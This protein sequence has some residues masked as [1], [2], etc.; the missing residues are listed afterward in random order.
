MIN[1]REFMAGTGLAGL[2]LAR[3]ARALAAAPSAPV[4]VA[5]CRSYGTEFL[6]ATEKMFDQ[7]GGLGRLVKG[8]TVTIKINLTG[9]ETTRLDYLPQGRTFWSHPRTVGAVIHLMDKAGARRIRVVEGAWV[10]PASLEEFMLKA[11][12]NPDLLLKAAPAVELINTNL[13]YKGS[14]PYTRFPVPRQG[15]LFP[16]YDL[17]TAYAESDVLVSMNKIKE[18]GTAGVT[19]SIKN[20]F[21]ISP[22]TIYGNKVPLDEPAPVPYGGRQEIGHNG[23]RQPPTSSPSEIDPKS[24]RQAGY[25][26][27]RFIADLVAA[28]PVHLAILD[29]IETITN[30]ELPRQDATRFVSPGVLVAGTN[31]VTTDAVAMAVMG[32]DP[33]A[34]RG[35]PPFENCD[36]TLRLAEELGVGTRDL[37]R[38]EVRGVPVREVV[39]SFREHGGPR[40]PRQ[41]GGRRGA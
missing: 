40:T 11:G 27:P 18:H 37:N 31:C 5:R 24:P 41:P 20:C 8:K 15:H 16:A 12:W 35:T 21:G 19:L 30:A 26:I 23:S 22:T 1:R 10:W 2:R 7:L 36:N 6:S 29:G 17:S 39:F 34:E 13:P 9:V 38:I 14:K 33:M 4:A 28:V 3:P 32:Y 25:R